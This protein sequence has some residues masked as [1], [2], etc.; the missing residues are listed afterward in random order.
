MLK[1]PILKWVDTFNAKPIKFPA[2]LF[3][4]TDKQILKFIQ[5]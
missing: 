2:G 4:E 3:V 1:L 5:Q